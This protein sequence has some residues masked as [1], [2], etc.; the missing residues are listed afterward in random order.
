MVVR[1]EPLR[2]RRRLVR[3]GRRIDRFFSQA[4]CTRSHYEVLR[5]SLIPNFM[6]VSAPTY[7]AY[8]GVGLQ[9]VFFFW[10]ENTVLIK[11]GYGLYGHLIRILAITYELMRKTIPRWLACAR[12][13]ID[14]RSMGGCTQGS[15]KYRYRNVSDWS[16]NSISYTYVTPYILYVLGKQEKHTVLQYLS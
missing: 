16:S 9:F 8:L 7:T 4:R 13:Y 1:H 15:V 2:C 10:K 5:M 12:I 14:Q 3:H 11:D 6:Y